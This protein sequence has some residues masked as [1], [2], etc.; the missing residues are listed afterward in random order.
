MVEIAEA[1][2]ASST[3]TAG[4]GGDGVALNENLLD[5]TSLALVRI[6]LRTHRDIPSP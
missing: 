3:Q 1:G 6:D 5:R 4:D 2:L